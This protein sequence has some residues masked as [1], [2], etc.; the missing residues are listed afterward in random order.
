MRYEPSLWDGSDPSYSPHITRAKDFFYW[1][2]SK[3]AVAAGFPKDLRK[4]PGKADDGQDLERARLCRDYTREM[5][6]FLQSIGTE[7]A[8]EPHTWRWLIGRYKSDE[9]S[10]FHGVKANT[11][12]SYL[13]DL[14]P[15]EEGIGDVKISDCTYEVVKRWHLKM[16]K[17]GRSPAYIAR[18]FTMLRIVAT[19]GTLIDA[20]G[21]GKVRDMLANMRFA[22]GNPRTVAPTEGQIMSIIAKADAAGDRGFALGLL[23]QWW[24]TLRAVDVRG[25]FLPCDDGKRRWCDGITWN[26]IDPDITTLEKV[27][28]K[29]RDSQPLAMR[30][31]LTLLPDVRARLQAIPADKR[32]GPVILRKNGLPYDRF[33]WSEAFR[34]YRDAAGVPAEVQ[35]M[36]TRAGAINHSKAK[37]VNAEDRQRQAN[38]ASPQTTEIYTRGHDQTR[39]NVIAIRAGTSSKL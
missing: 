21:A 17:K 36:D 22:R 25:H 39:N 38:H 16:Q 5:V 9:F 2:P 3:P 15:W 24:L 35:M 12:Q 33:E 13:D 32:I 4:L 8:I 20:P 1:R 26:M 34:T 10:P 6:Q 29:T 19:Y 23:L 14:K 31:D 27:A 18:K 37:G 11:R 30:F 7:S 28:S